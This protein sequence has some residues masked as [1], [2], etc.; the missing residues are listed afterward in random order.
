M[1]KTG[2]LR[3]EEGRLGGE[4]CR[5]QAG[6]EG[7]SVLVPVTVEEERIVTFD[8]PMAAVES[9]DPGDIGGVARMMGDPIDGLDRGLVGLLRYGEG[10]ADYVLT[11]TG[12]R[13]V[14]VET[15]GGQE[16][17]P[18]DVALGQSRRVAEVRLTMICKDQA[19]I[20]LQGRLRLF[21]GEK[22]ECMIF[23]VVDSR[24]SSASRCWV[25][26]IGGDR[27]PGNE[28]ELPPPLAATAGAGGVNR[29]PCRAV[30]RVPHRQPPFE[31]LIIAKKIRSP[32]IF[33]L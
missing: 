20:P 22:V 18:L 30:F 27:R 33:S 21:N 24:R 6:T 7:A 29:P 25:W 13:E 8:R 28:G 10:F 5:T 11:D 9:R 4:V 19:D 14:V 26:G 15:S 3:F 12:N 17:N 2:L 16:R 1:I 31:T 23:R 32:N